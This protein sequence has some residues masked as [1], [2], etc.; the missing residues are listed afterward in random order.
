[1][2]KAAGRAISVVS[3]ATVGEMATAHSEKNVPPANAEVIRAGC[4]GTTL[5]S[6]HITDAP[7]T[8]V[9]SARFNPKRRT[10]AAA[11]STA[12]RFPAVNAPAT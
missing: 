8:Q 3:A 11:G 5:R 9:N 10:T 6:E 7:A 12:T 2:L 4:P 1:M